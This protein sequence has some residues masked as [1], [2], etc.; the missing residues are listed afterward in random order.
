VIN[1]TLCEVACTGR[2]AY[3]AHIRGSK[4]L[5]T[6]KLHQKLG[7]PIPPDLLNPPAPAAAAATTSLPQSAMPASFSAAQVNYIAGVSVAQMNSGT[8]AGQAQALMDAKPAIPNTPSAIP[9]LMSSQI[10]QPAGFKNQPTTPTL[11]PKQEN[12]DYN[13]EEDAN[14]EPVGREYLETRVN[15]KVISFFCKLCDCQFNDPN[16]KEMHTK[17]KRHRLAYKVC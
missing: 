7:K 12:E 17:G 1:C 16:A 5:R 9:Q 11:V 8:A 6:L 4:H 15:G 13:E 3:A 14:C 10:S 2:D